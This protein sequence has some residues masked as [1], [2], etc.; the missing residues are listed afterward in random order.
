MK[1]RKSQAS[2]NAVPP[3]PITLLKRPAKNSFPA[4]GC[5]LLPFQQQPQPLLQTPTLITPQQQEQKQQRKPS[6]P[7]LLKRNSQPDAVVDRQVVQERMQ[8][9][10]EASPSTTTLELTPTQNGSVGKPR[11]QRDYFVEHWDPKRIQQALERGEILQGVVRFNMYNRHE[12]YISVPG[13]PVDI[14]VE[15]FAA[16]NR[17]IEGDKVAVKFEVVSAAVNGK[18]SPHSKYVTASIAVTALPESEDDVDALANFWKQLQF[19]HLSTAFGELYIHND[20]S[21]LSS[22][23]GNSSKR[24]PM[25]AAETNAAAHDLEELSAELESDSSKRLVGEVVGILEYSKRRS[26]IVGSLMP[27]WS[28]SA[29]SP[30]S[31][32]NTESPTKKYWKFVPR[33]ARMPPM[34]ILHDRLPGKL[35]AQLA[36]NTSKDNLTLL[37]ARLDTWSTS[38]FHPLGTVTEVLGGADEIEAQTAAIIAEYG[39]PGFDFP[40]EALADLPPS[41]WAVSKEE[42]KCRRDFRQER[43]FTIDPATARD[44]DDAVSIKTLPNGN[45]QVGVHIADVS[46]FVKP[47][48]E[49][50][51]EARRRSTSFYLTQK[52]I[53]MLPRRLCEELCSLN[54]NVER[55]T[56]SV[57]WDMTPSGEIV[58]QWMGRSIIKSCAKLSY[59]TAQRVIDNDFD[60]ASPVTYEEGIRPEQIACGHTWGDVIQDI[61]QLYEVSVLLRGKRFK[62]GALKLDNVKVS[63][64]LGDD[65]LPMF[66]R[67]YVT[68][69][70]N[71]LIEEFML[72]ANASVATTISRAYPD[73]A[74]LRRHPMPNGRK[75][76]DLERF[77]TE[78]GFHLDTSSAGALHDSL[79]QLQS[80]I[81]DKEVYHLLRNLATKSMNLAQYFSTG[82]I[83][84]ENDGWRH[85]ALAM[86]FYTHFTSPIRRYPDV[87]VH[88]IL[89]ATLEAEAS[90]A[91][92]QMRTALKKA[93][94]DRKDSTLPAL[95]PPR[96]VSLPQLFSGPQNQRLP[97]STPPASVVQVVTSASA[98]THMLPTSNEL[99]NISAHCNERKLA[100]RYS[101]EASARL[102]LSVLLQRQPAVVDAVVFNLGPR[103][104]TVLVPCFGL[105]RRIM[106][107]EMDKV[108]VLW[109]KA[110]NTV[111]LQEK[112]LSQRRL[113]K[114]GAAYDLSTLSFAQG[115]NGS[116]GESPQMVSKA[117]NKKQIMRDATKPNPHKIVLKSPEQCPP[118]SLPVTIKTFQHV[119]VLLSACGGGN[120][121]L[122]IKATLHVA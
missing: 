114:G 61:K 86:P 52:V 53:P 46:H 49:L 19:E 23:D 100:A 60:P 84:P 77:C 44:L 85:Y 89:A 80:I 13:L 28:T 48:T 120:K 64:Q 31:Q 43:V 56:F 12:S 75:L 116:A 95:L 98:A 3:P 27:T 32:P 4:N 6:H 105:E 109:D 50:D 111:T 62:A 54:P 9:A 63:V 18:R 38:C 40:R 92:G 119:P 20:T 106:L 14:C 67:T 66:A 7:I 96:S 2:Y 59:G 108:S 39:L 102:Y 5:E 29:D 72:L 113:K 30:T 21:P 70:A 35:K 65:Q 37:V 24:S 76:Q 16:Q 99:T 57:V 34:M 25:P 36:Q 42:I 87:L 81:Q 71:H 45:L 117:A 118:E 91:Q 47:G 93:V 73:R 15:G 88:R 69:E 51:A 26:A 112:V 58:G 83:S 107:D 68:G 74:L 17:S 121:L 11:Q 122:D 1:Q 41:P 97:P 94:S 115:G 22:P 101:Q 103:Y 90:L 10:L 33:D 79:E 110:S 8:T 104:M 82:A 55:L 78:H